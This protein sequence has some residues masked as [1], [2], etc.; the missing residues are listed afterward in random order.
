MWPTENNKKKIFFIHFLISLLY[1]PL[2]VL[3]D[4]ESVSSGELGHAFLARF[5]L[6]RGEGSHYV[7]HLPPGQLLDL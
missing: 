2:L 5:G 1:E 6:L 4:G 7:Y 3:S